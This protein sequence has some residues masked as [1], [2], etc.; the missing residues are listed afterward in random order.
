MESAILEYEET[1]RELREERIEKYFDREE[2]VEDISKDE[3]VMG[4]V[5]GEWHERRIGNVGGM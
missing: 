1:V 5:I 4:K 3:R 2:L